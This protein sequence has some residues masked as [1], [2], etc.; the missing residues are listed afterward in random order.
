MNENFSEVVKDL[1][2]FV[3]RQISDLVGSEYISL[4]LKSHQMSD[5]VSF[6]PNDRIEVSS[7]ISKEKVKNVCSIL[8]KA[9]IDNFGLIVA[10]RILLDTYQKLKERYSKKY[11]VGELLS[12]VV[13]TLLD[14]SK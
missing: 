4:L 7:Q 1:L 10:Q 12:V 8:I 13:P 6:L 11:P 2:S 3:T 14:I 5:V 9:V